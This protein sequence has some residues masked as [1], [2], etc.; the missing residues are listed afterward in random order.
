V[1]PVPS[2]SLWAPIASERALSA[3]TSAE[4]V[5]GCGVTMP[6]SM[7]TMVEVLTPPA[8]SPRAWRVSPS[9]SL[10]AR[11]DAPF[12]VT[13]WVAMRSSVNASQPSQQG[14]KLGRRSGVH[15]RTIRL[16]R[17]VR[18]CLERGEPLNL[19]VANL[20]SRPRE[21]GGNDTEAKAVARKLRHALRAAD[22]ADGQSTAPR[23]SSPAVA[24]ALRRFRAHSQRHRER[25]YLRFD[26]IAALRR[27]APAE[28]FESAAQLR[29]LHA[30]L[31][32]ALERQAALCASSD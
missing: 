22:H 11:S 32:R 4:S 13:I 30:E 31:V 18:D 7:R 5:L 27:N 21:E 17:Q 26:G 20:A 2:L 14:T 9:D 6:H 12:A 3:L 24:I 10:H 25:G 28:Y 8:S 19:L 16:G 23:S 1:V 29:H 15:A